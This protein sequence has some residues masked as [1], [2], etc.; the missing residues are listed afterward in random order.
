MANPFEQ[1]DEGA[2]GN[3]FDNFDGQQEPVTQ[4]QPESGVPAPFNPNM[5]PIEAG[6]AQL[7][8][9]PVSAVNLGK[10][11]VTP[12]VHPAETVKNIGTL[13]SGAYHKFTEGEQPDEATID[14]VKNFVIDRYGGLENIQRTAIEDP[15]GFLADVA[16]LVT[17]GGTALK[18]TGTLGKAPALVRAG[19]TA[20]KVG[21]VIDPV[22]AAT[23]ALG[24]MIPENLPRKMYASATKMT[25]SK[26][27]SPAKRL[28]TAQTGLDEAILPTQA[29]LNK[30]TREIDSVN[31]KIA[32]IIDD[33]AREGD[34]VP[35]SKVLKALDS[36]KQDAYFS[37]DRKK[38]FGII[39]KVEQKIKRDYGP[40]IPANAAQKLKQ[41]IYQEVGKFYGGRAAYVTEVKKAIALGAKEALA[42]KYPELAALNAKDSALLD[43]QKAIEASVKRIEN[44]DLVGIGLPIKATA[45]AVAGSGGGAAGTVAG[46][47]AGAV[48]GL[49]DTP[50]VKA[51][52]AIALNKARNSG[53]NRSPAKYAVRE[54][55]RQLGRQEEAFSG[56]GN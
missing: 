2:S 55:A 6:I 4:A 17:G 53:L 8:N 38:Y 27:V 45:G 39:N 18:A 12:F 47:I 41:N 50:I 15:V 10:N 52:L 54:T 35:R 43:L 14:A 30:L 48:S 3:P 31:Q 29:G 56:S 9:I 21:R 44:R 13:A 51:R 28:A 25:T 33:V 16:L 40:R 49:V 42:E 23:G 24:K 37:S 1:F 11:I 36:L 20:S 34:I 46:G 7:K 5:T 22:N 32:G 26:N 19:Q